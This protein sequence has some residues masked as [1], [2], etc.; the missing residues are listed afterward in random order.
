VL[1]HIKNQDKKMTMKREE[2]DARN[3]GQPT[4]RMLN[5]EKVKFQ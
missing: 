1:Q 3:R 4:W 2:V 5:I